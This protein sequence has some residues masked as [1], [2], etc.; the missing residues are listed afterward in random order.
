MN[1]KRRLSRVDICLVDERNPRFRPIPFLTFRKWPIVMISSETDTVENNA[2]KHYACDWILFAIIYIFLCQC[3]KEVPGSQILALKTLTSF[4]TF[5]GVV[6]LFLSLWF[7]YLFGREVE[8]H[9]HYSG[10]LLLYVLSAHAG[11]FV[12]KNGFG[13][14]DSNHLGSFAVAGVIGAMLTLYSTSKVNTGLENEFWFLGIK[15]S[16]IPVPVLV[17][18]WIIADVLLLT[19][20]QTPVSTIAGSAVALVAGIIITIGICTIQQNPLFKISSGSRNNSDRCPI[21]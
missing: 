13:V 14:Q 16:M 12:L 11:N 20:G 18:L 5:E 2:K 3:D 8:K 4:L 10:Y 15:S 7:L 21:Q 9:I 6:Q 1:E 17:A 19:T